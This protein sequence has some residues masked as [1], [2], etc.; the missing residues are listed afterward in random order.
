MEKKKRRLPAITEKEFSSSLILFK[1][2]LFDVQFSH[3]PIC[4]RYRSK[5]LIFSY[6]DYVE[7]HNV[8]SR[9]SWKNGSEKYFSSQIHLIE[10]FS[11]DSY[12]YGRSFE[13]LFQ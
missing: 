6:L 11:S 5:Q 8:L 2:L 10:M 12:Y 3:N 9:G 7:F 13:Q 4:S 1:S